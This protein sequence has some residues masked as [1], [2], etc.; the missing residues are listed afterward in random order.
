M[1]SD[2]SMLHDEAYAAVHWRYGIFAELPGK[3][4][5]FL[6]PAFTYRELRTLGC[7]LRSGTRDIRDL[8]EEF[9]D[10]HPNLCISLRV[11]ATREVIQAWTKPQMDGYAGRGRPRLDAEHPKPKAPASHNKKKDS[12]RELIEI[13]PRGRR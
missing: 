3:P 10:E 7:P 11:T 8:L 2:L 9:G 4:I 1:T 13:V 5:C 12:P 6:G